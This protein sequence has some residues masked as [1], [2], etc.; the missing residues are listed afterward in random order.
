[1]CGPE[2]DFGFFDA[3][4]ALRTFNVVE[5]DILWAFVMIAKSV[6]ADMQY[7]GGRDG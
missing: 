7:L 4:T 1:M 2:N 6:G 3:E 5:L